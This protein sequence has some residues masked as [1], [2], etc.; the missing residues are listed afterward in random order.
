MRSQGKSF[1]QIGAILIGVVYTAAG[2]IGFAVTGFD[3]I[4]QNT[5]YTLLSFDVNPF[6][7]IVH[8]GIGAYL[9]IMAQFASSI[10]EGALIG[11]GLFYL[12]AA[13]LGFTNSLQ[14]ISINSSGATDNFLHL[15][16]GSAAFAIGL[17][18]AL[19]GDRERARDP[20]EQA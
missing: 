1:A 17:I 11:G 14:I 12:L 19:R 8:L 20:I 7:D 13:F 6:H 10:T 18:S 2:L 15:V 16:S 3:D 9:L 4:V 5:N